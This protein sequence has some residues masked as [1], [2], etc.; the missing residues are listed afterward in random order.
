MKKQTQINICFMLLVIG[1]T[2]FILQLFV[3]E[4]P[5]GNIGLLLCLTSIAFI[6]GSIIKLCQLSESIKN[7]ILSI[8]DALFFI[9]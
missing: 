4:A 5:N 2:S 1:L 3:F 7:V 6:I 8:L 9:R